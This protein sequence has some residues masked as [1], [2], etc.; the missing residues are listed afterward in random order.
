MWT[1]MDIVVPVYNEGGNIGRLLA[2]I[3]GKVRT[4]HRIIIVYDFDQ[5]NTLPAARQAAQELGLDLHFLKNDL[6]RGVL[7]AIKAGLRFAD[8]ELVLVTMADLSDPAEVFDQLVDHAD[9]TGADIVCASRYM[10]G[11]RQVGGPL[12][13]RTLSRLAGL[14]LHYGAGLPTHDAAGNVLVM[15]GEKVIATLNPLKCYSHE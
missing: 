8:A 2:E 15:E 3:T 12:L 9:A 13:K 14:S 7:N 4:P 6:G 1:G 5:D 11:G 10:K